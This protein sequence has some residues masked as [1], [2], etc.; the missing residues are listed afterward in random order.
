MAAAN[1]V[2]AGLNSNVVSVTKTGDG[3]GIVSDS[4]GGITCGDLCGGSYSTGST[5]TLTAAPD[6]GYRVG[7]WSI[8]GCNN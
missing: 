1:L 5:I 3:T 8:P 2:A 6:A 7:G 4:T